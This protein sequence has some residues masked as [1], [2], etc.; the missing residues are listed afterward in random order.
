MPPERRL[1]F[2]LWAL[3]AML[4]GVTVMVIGLTRTLPALLGIFDAAAL[5]RRLSTALKQANEGPVTLASIEELETMAVRWLAL[6]KAPRARER[7]NTI[8][9]A[10]RQAKAAALAGRLEQ[11]RGYLRRAADD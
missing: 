11:A 10:V 3:G 5:W 4:V 8:L 9:A 6:A 1:E 7:A 2:A